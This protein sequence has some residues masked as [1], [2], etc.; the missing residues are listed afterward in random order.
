MK[1]IAYSEVPK[2]HPYVHLA[3]ISAQAGAESALLVTAILGTIAFLVVFAI[4]A[5]T[6]VNVKYAQ[7][8]RRTAAFCALAIVLLVAYR[9]LGRV[10]LGTR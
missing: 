8:W 3:Y 5:T 1:T 6:K 10:T 4:G 9:L 7:F 2:P